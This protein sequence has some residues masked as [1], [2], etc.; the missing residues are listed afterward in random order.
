MTPNDR[1]KAEIDKQGRKYSW[2]AEK[3]SVQLSTLSETLNNKRKLTADEVVIYCNILSIP[4][5]IILPTKFDNCETVELF[6]ND[7]QESEVP[8]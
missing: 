2:I 4:A 3:A 7:T 8:A 5:S 1:L 6:K